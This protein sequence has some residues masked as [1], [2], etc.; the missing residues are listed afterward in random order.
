MPE[1]P[2]RPSHPY[3]SDPADEPPT[4][5]PYARGQQP[6]ARDQ[7]PRN[8]DEYGYAS[9]DYG[10]SPGERGWKQPARRDE[11]SD[12]G[13]DFRDEDRPERTDRSAYSLQ[14][15]LDRQAQDEFPEPSGRPLSRRARREAER[16][17]PETE[18]E[19]A[20]WGNEGPEPRWN[21]RSRLRSASEIPPEEAPRSRYRNLGPL[22]T[23]MMKLIR[24][25]RRVEPSDETNPHG[26]RRDE[27]EELKTARRRPSF[28]DM[29]SEARE[30]GWTSG[31]QES[32]PGNGASFPSLGGSR[33]GP[34]PRAAQ[35]F[36][37]PNPRRRRAP[38]IA[39]VLA[40]LLVIGGVVY[41][42]GSHG[43]KGSGSA[44]DASAAPSAVGSTPKASATKAAVTTG[45]AKKVKLGVFK[46]GSSPSQISTFSS[47]LGR[48][49]DYAVDYSTRSTWDEIANPTY[50]LSAWRNSGYRMVYAVAMLPTA[51]SS[52][53]TLADGADGDYDH[54]YETLA[55]NLVAYGQ[56]DSIIRLGWEFNVGGWPWHPGL[57]DQKDFVGYWRHIVKAMRSV[58]GAEKLQF[59]WNVNNGGDS[60][61]STL[62]YPG[63]KYVDYI[64]VDVYDTSWD[65]DAYPYPGNCDATCKLGHQQVAWDDV[66]GATFGLSF[67]SSF[68]QSEGKKLSLPE[69]GLWDR[70]DGHGGGDD[71]YFVQQMYKFIDDPTNNVGY[72]AYFDYNTDSKGN[73]KLET[74]SK[75]GA[76]YQKLF[77]K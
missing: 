56:G 57:A 32:G 39:G 15:R 23:G 10:A 29:E 45:A 66:I 40:V 25:N 28:F 69:W 9:G 65:E 14:N 61:D 13:R 72:Q 19:Q 12:P 8:D 36:R 33:T 24:G 52:G 64:G 6:G 26:L 71:T 55:R 11:W 73:H 34:P 31:N 3:G 2:V 5:R 70:P 62:F 50:M 37:Q 41:A 60:Y 46:G 68:A 63:K 49:V 48:D 43:S 16:G 75:A 58:S 21:G 59:D 53:A 30:P 27:E 77:G 4:R 51:K 47:W 35:S 42:L 17:R 74:L 38:L 7:Y 67:W 44:A 22:T 20:A 54:Y 1:Y 18:D 76:K